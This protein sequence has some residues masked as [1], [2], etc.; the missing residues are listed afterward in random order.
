MINIRCIHFVYLSSFSGI[1]SP[2]RTLTRLDIWSGSTMSRCKRDTANT[3]G[4]TASVY[5]PQIPIISTFQHPISSLQLARVLI[6][7]KSA[8]FDFSVLGLL[9][10]VGALSF[11]KISPLTALQHHIPSPV[12]ETLISFRPSLPYTQ[13]YPLEEY[14]SERERVLPCSRDAYL[15]SRRILR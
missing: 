7:S 2:T 9:C 1:R 8:S 12:W 6:L 15:V 11:Y 10:C 4:G 3:T 14:I 5:L 13:E